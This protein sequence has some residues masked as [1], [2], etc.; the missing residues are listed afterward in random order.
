MKMALENIDKAYHVEGLELIAHSKPDSPEY[1]GCESLTYK[2]PSGS[3]FAIA[4]DDWGIQIA[5]NGCFFPPYGTPAHG[6]FKSLKHATDYLREHTT[7]AI[8]FFDEVVMHQK[9][10]KSKSN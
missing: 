3:K 10:M 7:E 5:S 9:R 4:K 2:T 8:V 1:K 6:S